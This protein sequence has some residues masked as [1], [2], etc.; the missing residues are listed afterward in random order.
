MP[1][2]DF[3]TTRMK[4]AYA[5]G[6]GKPVA[7]PNS[8]GDLATPTVVNYPEAGPPLVGQDAYE[9]GFVDPTNTARNFKLL[10]GSTANILGNGRNITPTDAAGVAIAA[11]TQD[12]ERATNMKLKQVVATCPANFQDH[13]KQA[14]IEAFGRAGLEILLLIPEPTAAGFAYSTGVL[15]RDALIAVYDFGG[16]TFDVSILKVE[17]HQITVLATEGVAKLGGN[18]INEK[19]R[20]MV[21]DRVQNELGATPDPVRDALFFM[22]LDQKAEQAKISLG[23]RQEVPIV[24]SYGGKQVI[25]KVNR[26]EFQRSIDPLIEQSLGA[27]DRAVAAASIKVS[28]VDRLL[29]VGGTSHQLYIQERVAN[30]TGLVPRVDVDPDKAV[31]YGAALAYVTERARR[32]QQS[33]ADG[34]VI[35]TPELTLRDVTAHD[36]GC[37]ALYDVGPNQKLRNA[38]IIRKNTQIPCQR[39]E[40]FCLVHEDQT[41]VL[42]EV[43]QGPPDAERDECLLIGEFT[44]TGLPKEKIR[45]PRLQIEYVIDINGMVTATATDKVSGR[46]QTVTVDYKKGIK[47][48]AKPSS[49]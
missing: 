25:V 23:T 5:D 38:V 47:P 42:I 7:V 22:E 32:G 31:V 46:T 26:S 2:I 40:H 29:M 3:G 9:Q 14:L 18:D 30:H 1:A 39:V 13:Q 24:I 43:L 49:V 20:G 37:C 4:A 41:D 17:G 21:L 34:K 19:L 12:L 36:V 48:K 44:M 28:D 6:S 27:F 35:P 16:G 15:G 45:T 33:F 8:R 11:V 10:L